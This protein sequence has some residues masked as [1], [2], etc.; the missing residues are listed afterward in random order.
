MRIK[1]LEHELCCLKSI[2]LVSEAALREMLPRLE[3]HFDT[4][5][6]GNILQ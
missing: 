1:N 5:V 4:H 2:T 3:I 6:K